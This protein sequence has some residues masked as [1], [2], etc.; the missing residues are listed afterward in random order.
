MAV[1]SFNHEKLVA[2]QQSLAFNVA[3]FVDGG[4]VCLLF[5]VY[6]SFSPGGNHP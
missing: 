3:N 2:C 6:C 1:I 5:T 4:K